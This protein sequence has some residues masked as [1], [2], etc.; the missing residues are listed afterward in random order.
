MVEADA[1]LQV[2]DDVLDDG[3]AAVVGLEVQ[4]PAVAVGDEGVIV[5]GGEQGE[6]AARGG[7]D[8][9]HDEA[10]LGVLFRERPVGRL[11]CTSARRSDASNASHVIHERAQSRTPVDITRPWS[12]CGATSCSPGAARSR[13][14]GP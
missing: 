14:G 13:T 7:L 2:S 11:G 9:P 5:V 12:S 10:H 4:G 3:M 6:L 8:P 1:V